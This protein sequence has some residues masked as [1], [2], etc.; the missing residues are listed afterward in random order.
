M[1]RGAWQACIRID[2]IRFHS[3]RTA[4]HG[5]CVLLIVSLGKNKSKNE[6]FYK[7]ECLVYVLNL[8]SR[9]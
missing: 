7:P 1:D 4:N 5:L 6:N 3:C 2:R 9:V 8:F